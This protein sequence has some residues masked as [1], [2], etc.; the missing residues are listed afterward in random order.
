MAK[1]KTAKAAPKKNK[2]PAAAKKTSRIEKLEA[3][4]SELALKLKALEAAV[5]A[6]QPKSPPPPPKWPTWPQPDT[7]PA[8]WYPIW[9]N[10][11]TTVD[12]ASWVNKNNT[13]KNKYNK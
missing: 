12:Y 5:N 1:K 10:I 11:Y 8:P 4:V 9:H 13:D 3:V 2:K 7:A 6:L